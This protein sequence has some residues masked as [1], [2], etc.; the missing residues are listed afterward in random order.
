MSFQDIVKFFESGN[1]P[2]VGFVSCSA[3][4]AKS[5]N[6]LTT[7]NPEQ[8]GVVKTQF[9]SKDLSRDEKANLK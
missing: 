5:T 9:A 6:A 8:R 1:F 2:I 4:V 7:S 3:F